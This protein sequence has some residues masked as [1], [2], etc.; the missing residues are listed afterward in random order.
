MGQSPLELSSKLLCR[1]LSAHLLMT[2]IQIVPMRI[3][4]SKFSTSSTVSSAV[5][6]TAYST[7]HTSSHKEGYLYDIRNNTQQP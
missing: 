6:C 5:A 4:N 3:F 1:N 2:R 7:V